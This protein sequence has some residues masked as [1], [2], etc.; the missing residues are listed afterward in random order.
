MTNR[1]LSVKIDITIDPYLLRRVAKAADKRG[2]TRSGIIRQALYDWL[3]K[4][5]PLRP[6]LGLT[7]NGQPYERD[8]LFKDYLTENMTLEQSMKALDEFE[9]ACQNRY[10]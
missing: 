10:E 6:K 4:N 8:K 7:V 2:E 5:A 3:E 9:Y 1:R